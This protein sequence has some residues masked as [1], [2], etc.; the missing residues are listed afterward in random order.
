MTGPSP[1]RIPA[2]ALR[3]KFDQIL[4]HLDERR[5]R[6]WYEADVIVMAMDAVAVAPV[7][8]QIDG[9]VRVDVKEGVPPAAR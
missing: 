2:A 5:R 6:L 9:T 1:D 4:P 7:G 3:V 8:Q